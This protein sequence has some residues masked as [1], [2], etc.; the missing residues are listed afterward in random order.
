MTLPHNTISEPTLHDFIYS[1]P[2]P[3]LQLNHLMEISEWNQAAEKMF[4]YSLLEVKGKNIISILF[5]KSSQSIFTDFI[6]KFKQH[7]SSY[8]HDFSNISKSGN[9]LF[10][11]W[12]TSPHYIN[13]ELSE[14]TIII[15]DITDHR[16][17][18][19]TLKYREHLFRTVSEQ[20]IVGMYITK[21]NSLFFVNEGFAHILGFSINEILKW[22]FDQKLRELIHPEDFA[23]GYQDHHLKK[24]NLFANEHQDYRI[25]TKEGGWKWVSHYSKPISTDFGIL[26]QGIIVDINTQKEAQLQLE[27]SNARFQAIT[28]QS[29]VGIT[30]TQDGITKYTNIANE[31]ITGYS[32]LERQ[33]W[34]KDENLKLIHPDDRQRIITQFKQDQE[35]DPTK[36]FEYTYRI[37][38]KDHTIKWI[39]DYSK[40]IK[41]HRRWAWLSLILDVTEKHLMEREISKNQKLESLGILAGGIA[42]DFNNLLTSIIGNL[43]IALLELP[44]SQHNIREI[45]K[46]AEDACIR[47]AQLTKQLL[48]FSKGGA[49]IKQSTTILDILKDTITFLLR[50]TSIKTIY[51]IDQNLP[52]VHID[53]GQISQVIQNI[54]INAKQAMPMG[55]SLTIHASRIPSSEIL[56]HNIM[57]REK[58]YILI[59]ISDTGIGIPAEFLSK[60]FDPYFSTKESGSGLGLAMCYSIIKKHDGWI[61]VDSTVGEGTTFKI[62]LPEYVPQNKSDL[63]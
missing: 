39:E 55:G 7:E 53:A 14:I 33:K 63:N 12:A 61:Q 51:D 25:R 4:E 22:N 57:L 9:E 32:N 2:L 52:L 29:I 18:H 20:S 41:I 8:V 10:C 50:G 46:E 5:P 27:E 21:D 62:Y 54:V 59:S 44:E 49:P 17:T 45:V 26:I 28:E 60:I 24:Q 31:L 56:D 11:K 13:G 38:A 58:N 34:E 36:V 37:I 30:L 15:H 23:K 35:A 42:H 43:S 16:I 40:R 47:A 1:S 19:E 6:S 3:M 48:T